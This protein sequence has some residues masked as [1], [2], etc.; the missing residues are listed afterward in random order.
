ML[1]G[2]LLAGPHITSACRGHSYVSDKVRVDPKLAPA[3]TSVQPEVKSHLRNHVTY[4]YQKQEVKDQ[5]TINLHWI[6][7]QRNQ[8]LDPWKPM[9]KNEEQSAIKMVFW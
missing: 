3:W 9:K 1:V 2:V 8:E 6:N 7:N 5:S 4:K